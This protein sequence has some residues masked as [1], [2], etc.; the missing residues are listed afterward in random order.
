MS[1]RQIVYQIGLDQIEKNHPDEAEVKRKKEEGFTVCQDGGFVGVLTRI[2][3]RLLNP[4][5]FTD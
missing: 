3:T 2:Y 4:R 5:F 1:C